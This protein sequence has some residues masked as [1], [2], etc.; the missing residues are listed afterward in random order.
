MK[1][2]NEE[3]AVNC[4]L[5][6]LPY[7]TGLEYERGESPDDIDPKMRENPEE[8]EVDFVLKAKTGGSLIAVEHTILERFK[9]QR[10]YG[11]RSF[12][13]VDRV[14]EKCL[15]LL[16]SDRYYALVP[17]PAL[18]PFGKDVEYRLAVRAGAPLG[19]SALARSSTEANFRRFGQ[20]QQGV[21]LRRLNTEAG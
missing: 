5:Q 17:S 1:K 8:P 14:A 13:I 18:C 12:D 16:P 4:L 7:F 20:L 9:G 15:G 3:D 11:Y 19:C 2:P 6:I 21:F 10:G